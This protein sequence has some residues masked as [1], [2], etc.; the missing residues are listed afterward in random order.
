MLKSLALDV[1]N[2]NDPNLFALAIKQT[3]HDRFTGPARARDR[4]CAPGLVHVAGEATDKGFVC[5]D[6][7]RH[8]LKRSG[9]HREP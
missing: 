1:P 3:Q 2:V 8:L 7:A 5:L 4:L 9:L 6:L